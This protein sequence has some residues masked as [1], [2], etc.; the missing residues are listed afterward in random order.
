MS[1]S[2]KP[3]K[4]EPTAEQRRRLAAITDERR[5]DVL[6]ARIARGETI[7]EVAWQ[8][9]PVPLEEIP[10]DLERALGAM[11]GELKSLADAYGMSVPELLAQLEAAEPDEQKE[12]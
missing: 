6:L 9:L 2:D 5:R 10:A 11:R 4:R 12:G 3:S 7:P 1:T 8:Q